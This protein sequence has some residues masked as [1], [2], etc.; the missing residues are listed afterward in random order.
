MHLEFP[1][2]ISMISIFLLTINNDLETQIFIATD[3][4]LYKAI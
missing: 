2:P 3:I 1:P 4:L